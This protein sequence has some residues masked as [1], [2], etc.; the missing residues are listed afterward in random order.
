MSLFNILLVAV[1]LTIATAC[2]GETYHPT[3]PAEAV[4]VQEHVKPAEVCG[5]P[6]TFWI[7]TTR[8]VQVSV[9]AGTEVKVAVIPDYVVGEFTINNGCRVVVTLAA[10][11][12]AIVYVSHDSQRMT[13]DEVRAGEQRP[14]KA[15]DFFATSVDR[16]FPTVLTFNP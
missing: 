9:N 6:Y 12:Y 10:E 2:E 16:N 1:L 3:T 13:V 11:E 7:E 15:D 5:D 4:V 14:E 8:T